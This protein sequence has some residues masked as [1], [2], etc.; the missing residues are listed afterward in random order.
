M[1]L[2]QTIVRSLI[3]LLQNHM[4]NPKTVL[5]YCSNS[6]DLKVTVNLLI[7]IVVRIAADWEKHPCHLI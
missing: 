3:K 2:L 4:K 1:L 6:S 7:T 5:L